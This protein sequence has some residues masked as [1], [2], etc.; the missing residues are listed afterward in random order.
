MKKVMHL[1]FAAACTCAVSFSSFAGIPGP[2][3]CDGWLR[4]LQN[5]ESGNGPTY[6]MTCYEIYNVW[7]DCRAGEWNGLPFAAVKEFE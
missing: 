2:G 3:D 6:G 1:A 5:C 4:V 7:Q